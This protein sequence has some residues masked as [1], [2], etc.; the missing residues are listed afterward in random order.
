[1]KLWTIQPWEVWELLQYT[2]IYQCD[3]TRVTMSAYFDEKYRCLN[4]KMTTRIG[5][6]PQGVIYPVWAWYK[7]NGRH[8][9]PDLRSERRGCGSENENYTCIELEVPEN[10]VLLSDFDIWHII[11]N[12]GLISDSEEESQAQEALYNALSAAQKRAYKDK[13]W[14][15][16]F[17]VSPLKNGWTICGE[18][19]QATCWDLRREF[20]LSVRFF[21]TAKAKEP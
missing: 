20:I 1:M 12:D 4:R 11:L 18:W 5:S 16:V 8:C 3:P 17:D 15:R 7:Q 6:P 9:K 14:E 10:Q 19:V 21:R 2:G 13:T